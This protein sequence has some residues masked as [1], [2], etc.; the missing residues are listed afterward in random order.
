MKIEA[1]KCKCGSGY[2]YDRKINDEKGC[3]SCDPELG[4]T[5]EDR[6]KLYK[7]LIVTPIP[8]GIKSLFR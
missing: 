4:D 7:Q 5:T 8:D 2:Y 3:P 6:I 1:E